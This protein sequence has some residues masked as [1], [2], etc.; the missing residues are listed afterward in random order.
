MFGAMEYNIL[1]SDFVEGA[2][3]LVTDEFRRSAVRFKVHQK[4]ISG[5]GIKKYGLIIHL[6]RIK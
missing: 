3:A 5:D 6:S 4:Y 2:L 1:L